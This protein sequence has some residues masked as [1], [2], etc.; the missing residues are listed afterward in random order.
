MS[1]D[2]G[3]VELVQAAVPEWAATGVALLTQLGDAWFLVALLGVL[4]WTQRDDQDDIVLV[5]GA[6]LAG[7][8]LYRGIKF[9][10]ELPRPD[11]PLVEPATLG[12]VAQPLYEATASASGYGFPSGHA[13]SSAVVY[14]GLAAV[15]SVWTLRR[16]VAV[17]TVLVAVVS[18]TRV[19]LGVHYLVDVVVGAALG[20]FLV[21]LSVPVLGRLTAD[22]ETPVLVSAV[23]ASWVYLTASGGETTAVLLA[24][25]ALGLLAGWQLV[26]LGRL[27]AETDS[28]VGLERV[29]VVLAAVSL[30]SLLLVLAAFPFLSAE[31]YAVSGAGVVGLGVA[32]GVIVPVARLQPE[33]CG[34]AIGSL[35]E[36]LD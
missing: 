28:T 2:V 11:R 27:T 36:R 1:R 26:V 10:F 33:R 22:R 3:A 19:A 24:G 32:V 29:R 20:G 30:L 21:F 31:R 13:T 34:Q 9:T 18:L 7:A 5:G 8:G 16:R 14:F 23:L 6:L 25:G 12:A 15:L 35:R 4:Y 17:A